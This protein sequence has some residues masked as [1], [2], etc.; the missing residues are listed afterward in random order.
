[1][2]SIPTNLSILTYGGNCKGSAVAAA[3]KREYIELSTVTH[4]RNE[5][6]S[7]QRSRKEL[8]KLCGLGSVA[9]KEP[10]SLAGAVAQ[11]CKEG[12]GSEVGDLDEAVETALCYGW[13]DGQKKP[14]DDG[15]WLQKFTRRGPKSIWA[16]RNREKAE[17]LIANGRMAAAGQNAVD[18]ARRDGRWAAAYDSP[19]SAEVPPDLQKELDHNPAAKAF[20]ASLDSANRYA[21]LFRIHTA[22]KETTRARRI[23]QFVHML[24]EGKKI[25]P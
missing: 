13:I 12:I 4:G 8:Q 23:Q 18:A 20:F 16:K 11:A 1:M 3:P 22:K 7:Q 21:I 5:G 10:R 2:E 9:G 24:E 15:F 6:Y 17:K 14:F 19:R 25:H